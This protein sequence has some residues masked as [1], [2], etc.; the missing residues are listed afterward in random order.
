MTN[1]LVIDDDTRL[2]ELLAMYL[3]GEGYS[4]VTAQHAEEARLKLAESKFDILVMD[5]M[6]PGEDGM[7][8]TKSL[9]ETTTIPILMLTAMGEPDDRIKGLES[10]ADDYLTKPFEPRELCLRIENILKRQPDALEKPKADQI[11]SFGD[12]RFNLK[13]GDLYKG[14]EFV[15]LTSGELKLLN[16]FAE[17]IDNPVSRED[18]SNIFNGISERSVDV[19]VNRLRKKIEKDPKKPFI[20]QTDRGSGYV[21]RS[22]K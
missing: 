17:N 6:M 3:S 14:S 10:G 18:L 9:R 4:V 16:I 15:N 2:R 22:R 20:L 5:I 12:F 11:V 8:L 7:K 21:L 13:T 19:Q 1:I